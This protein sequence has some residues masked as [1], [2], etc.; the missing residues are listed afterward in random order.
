MVCRPLNRTRA[1]FSSR[2]SG[3]LSDCNFQTMTQAIA[4]TSNRR[5]M[6][7][8]VSCCQLSRCWPWLLSSM[9]KLSIRQRQ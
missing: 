7:M 5:A 3:D 2:A 6:A 9:K 8:P 1:V 4:A